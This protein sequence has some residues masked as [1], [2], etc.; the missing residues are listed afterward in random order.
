MD[1]YLFIPPHVEK[2][3]FILKKGFFCLVGFFPL[4]QI[5]VPSKVLDWKHSGIIAS[6]TRLSIRS[7]HRRPEM[8]I[9]VAERVFWPV[10]ATDQSWC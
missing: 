9:C 4:L 10:L 8:A 2:V 6:A 5:Q 7:A 1:V 3:P